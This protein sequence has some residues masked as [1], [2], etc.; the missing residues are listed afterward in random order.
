MG[1]GSS[2]YDDKDDQE[3]LALH[4]LSLYNDE[5][6]C[7]I[8][9]KI[10]GGETLTSFEEELLKLKKDIV[11][12]TKQPF[13]SYNGSLESLATV[14]SSRFDRLVKV[15]DFDSFSC[16]QEKVTAFEFMRGRRYLLLDRILQA[17]TNM[18]SHQKSI[19][20]GGDSD[21][22]KKRSV[23]WNLPATQSGIE[24]RNDAKVGSMLSL[25]MTLSLAKTFGSQNSAMLIAILQNLLQSWS[26]FESLCFANSSALTLN[27]VKQFE[28]FAMDIIGT[29]YKDGTG[30]ELKSLAVSFLFAIGVLRGSVELISEASL[31]L[32]NLNL[33]LD[34]RVYCL[35]KQ[36]ENIE[37][38]YAMHF[39]QKCGVAEKIPVGSLDSW[40]EEKESN[41][42]KCVISRTICANGSHVYM[43][44]ENSSSLH[45][46]STGGRGNVPGDV[47][48]TCKDVVKTIKDELDKSGELKSSERKEKKTK[49]EKKLMTDC[50]I[51]TI[52][53]GSEFSVSENKLRVTHNDSNVEHWNTVIGSKQIPNLVTSDYAERLQGLTYFEVKIVSCSTD[54]T[55]GVIGV[56]FC[57]QE[58]TPVSHADVIGSASSFF[59]LNYSFGGLL[60][61]NGV[62]MTDELPSFTTG[63]IIGC[64]MDVTSHSIF[65][66]KNGN[67]IGTAFSLQDESV[68]A[69]MLTPAVSFQGGHVSEVEVNFGQSAFSYSGEG[70]KG[71]FCASAEDEREDDDESVDK[72]EEMR[73]SLAYVNGKIYFHYKKYLRSNQF[74]VFDSN[75][76]TF[77]GIET[78]S[79]TQSDELQIEQFSINLAT[80]RLVDIQAQ[81]GLELEL[82]SARLGDQDITSLLRESVLFNKSWLLASSQRILDAVKATNSMDTVLNLSVGWKEIP[83]KVKMMLPITSYQDYIIGV[84]HIGGENKLYSAYRRL[85]FVNSKFSSGSADDDLIAVVSTCWENYLEAVA[86]AKET[87]LP[88]V[89]KTDWEFLKKYAKDV[90]ENEVGL[91]LEFTTTTDDEDPYE[92][93]YTEE[94]GVTWNDIVECLSQEAKDHGDKYR[95]VFLDTKDK[96]VKH[97]FDLEL[98][99]APEFSKSNF[100]CMELYFNGVQLQTNL[101][102]VDEETS[103]ISSWKFSFK[104]NGKYQA[105]EAAE[106]DSS[107]V[108]YNFS[109]NCFDM[110][111]NTFFALTPDG[112][113]VLRWK[114]FG[115]SPA[116]VSGE[117]LIKEVGGFDEA[118]FQ[119][120]TPT[121]QSHSIMQILDRISGP[122]QVSDSSLNAQNSRMLKAEIRYSDKKPEVLV[123]VAGKPVCFPEKSKETT[124]VFVVVFDA[125]FETEKIKFFSLEDEGAL[126]ATRFVE[127]IEN[128]PL[129]QCV[130]VVITDMHDE[131]L[132]NGAFEIL[133][134]IGVSDLTHSSSKYLIAIGRKGLA[135]GL[136]DFVAEDG[137]PNCTLSRLLPPLQVP[138]C[139]EPT[140]RTMTNLLTIC[141]ACSK[142]YETNKSTDIVQ[143]LTVVLNLLALNLKNITSGLPVKAYWKL[144]GEDVIKRLEKSLKSLMTSDLK[145]RPSLQSTIT[146]M[147]YASMD[148]LYSSSNQKIEAL[149]SYSEG[150]KVSSTSA[151]AS[152]TKSAGDSDIL[153][154]LLTDVSLPK[155]YLSSKSRSGVDRNH[156]TAILTACEGLFRRELRNAVD[157]Y[158]SDG[159]YLQESLSKLYGTVV[160]VLSNI[161]TNLLA[162]DLRTVEIS[163]GKLTL[164]S[165]SSMALFLEV[166]TIMARLSADL[167]TI[168]SSAFENRVSLT[169]DD[170]LLELLRK[171]FFSFLESSPLASILP[172]II[173]AFTRLVKAGGYQFTNKIID[174]ALGLMKELDRCV[175]S[176]GKVFALVPSEQ[177]KISDSVPQ[178]PIKKKVIESEHP[179][180]SNMNEKSVFSFPGATKVQIVFDQAT[181]TETNCDYL[182]FQDKEG[183][184]LHPECSERF[185]G[186]DGGQNWPGTDGRPPLEMNVSEFTVFFHSDGSVE[187]WGYK[188]TVT[189]FF[190]PKTGA[191]NRLE[192]IS[193]MNLDLVEIQ[194]ALAVTLVQGPSWKPI[195]DEYSSWMENS[196]VRP[197]YF[198]FNPDLEDDVDRF[199]HD[200][201]ELP[202]DTPAAHFLQV[203]RRCV[204][205]DQGSVEAINRS[206]Y[207]TCAA[208]IRANNLSSE[209]YAIAT[210]KRAQPSDALVKAWTTGQKMREYF[211]LSDVKSSM[212]GN[213]NNGAQRKPKFSLYEGAPEEVVEEASKEIVARAQ[214][215]LRIPKEKDMSNV[216]SLPKEEDVDPEQIDLELDS[217]EA[218]SPIRPGST[219]TSG[220]SKW[221]MAARG[222]QMMRQVSEETRKANEIWHSLVGEAV[223]KEKLKNI[224]EH[225]RKFAEKNKAANAMTTT[226]KVLHFVQSDVDIARLH[227][228]N[229]LRNKRAISRTKGFDMFFKLLSGLASFPSVVSVV[230]ERFTQTMHKLKRE[231]GTAGTMVHYST[232]LEG[233]S[234]EQNNLLWQKFSSIYKKCVEII[235]STSL[236]EKNPDAERTILN[237]LHACALDFDSAD[238]TLVYESGL[239][240]CLEELLSLKASSTPDITQ[241]AT[242]LFELLVGR[243]VIYE[244]NVDSSSTEP[245]PLS[246]KLISALE[247]LLRVGPAIS[248]NPC[249]ASSELSVLKDKILETGATVPYSAQY[250]SVST[251][252]SS[253]PLAHT[254]VFWVKRKSSAILDAPFSYANLVGRVVCLGVDDKEQMALGQ[255]I[256]ANADTRKVKIKSQDRKEVEFTLP[257]GNSLENAPFNLMDPTV[258]GYLFSKGASGVI[259][260]ADRRSRVPSITSIEGIL[261]NDGRIQIS[262]SFD[263]KDQIRLYSKAIPA[264]VWVQVAVTFDHN[265]AVSLFINAE[266]HASR[267]AG[268]R[269]SKV[270]ELESAHPIA[271]LAN[272]NEALAVDGSSTLLWFDASTKFSS[273]TGE[274][275]LSQ[276]DWTQSFSVTDQDDFPGFNG[277]EAVLR[278]GK[279]NF[280]YNGSEVQSNDWGYKL[281][282]RGVSS[283]ELEEARNAGTRLSWYVGQPPTYVEASGAASLKGASAIVHHLQVFGA[284]L[285]KEQLKLL[286]T[287]DTTIAT[288]DNISEPLLLRRLSVL[289]RA[290]SNL[291]NL[292]DLTM[293]RHFGTSGLISTLFDL[294]SHRSAI[295]KCSALQLARSILPQLEREYVDG[296]AQR[297]GMMAG[298]AS[299]FVESVVFQVGESLNTWI[300][301]MLAMDDV[302]ESCPRDGY[303]YLHSLTAIR[304]NLI[305][306][307]VEHKGVW[308]ELSKKSL[309]SLSVAA[310]D[311]I[312]RLKDKLKLERDQQATFSVKQL[313][314][315]RESDLQAATSVFSLLSLLGGV[316]NSIG[317]GATVLYVDSDS[318]I[319]EEAIYLGPIEKEKEKDLFSTKVLSDDDDKEFAA[320][321]L[322]RK[323]LKYTTVPKS[324]ITSPNDISVDKDKFKSFLEDCF[325]HEHLIELFGEILDIS[326]VDTRAKPS[327]K[328]EKV[329]VERVFESA[330]PYSDNFEFSEEI[331]IDGAESLEIFFDPQSSTEKDCDF[332]NFWKSSDRSVRL[333]SPF[334][335]RNGTQNWPGCEGRPSLVVPGS[336]VFYSFQTDASNNDWGYKFTVR[337]Q[338]KRQSS[339]G[340]LKPLPVFSTLAQI[341]MMGMKS[342]T[343]VAACSNDVVRSLGG[344]LS[345]VIKAAIQPTPANT[346]MMNEK[347][348]MKALV[349]ESSHP[350][351]DNMDVV[352]PVKVP[353]AKRFIISFD[354]ETRTENNCDYLEFYTDRNRGT[355]CPN[356][357]KYTGG[358]DGGTSNWP[359]MKDRPPLIIEGDSFAFFFHS[360][361]SVNDWGYKMYVQP[362][363]AKVKA[364]KVQAIRGAGFSAVAAESSF[365][366]LQGV[367]LDG[368]ALPA[369]R[370]YFQ[371]AV[372]GVAD[373]PEY[374]ERSILGL[375]QKRDEILSQAGQFVVPTASVNKTLTVKLSY[376][377]A[378]DEVAVYE[379]HDL[380]SSVRSTIRR[381]QVL[382]VVEEWNDWLK[383][384]E[385]RDQRNGPVPEPEIGWIQRRTQ[386]QFSL[387]LT[388]TPFVQPMAI[389]TSADDADKKKITSKDHPMYAVQDGTDEQ[390]FFKKLISGKVDDRQLLQ[391]DFP[392]I[393]EAMND[394]AAIASGEHSKRLAELLMTRNDDGYN[395]EDLDLN[396]LMSYLNISLSEA[397]DEKCVD[398]ERAN[399][400]ADAVFGLILNVSDKFGLEESHSA[401]VK[402]VDTSLDLIKAC[403]T[404]ST[405]SVSA[406]TQRGYMMTVESDHQYENNM[407]KDWTVSFPGAKRLELVF[408]E[409]CSTETNCDY[410]NI[411]DVQRQNK[412]Y[413]PKIHGYR[414]VSNKHWPGVGGVP[415]LVLEHDSCIINFVTD[416]STVDWGF[417]VVVYGIYDEASNEEVSKYE[418][419]QKKMNETSQRMLTMAMWATHRLAKSSASLHSS[420]L[421]R[422]YSEENFRIMKNFSLLPVVANHRDEMVDIL[423]SFVTNMG[424]MIMTNASLRQEFVELESSIVNT[425]RLAYF[426]ETENGTKLTQVST[427]LQAMVQLVLALHQTMSNYMIDTSII[428]SRSFALS[429]ATVATEDKFSFGWKT[430][431]YDHRSVCNAKTLQWEI[432]IVKMGSTMP[433]VGLICNTSTKMT[434]SIGKNAGFCEIGY[435]GNSVN[436]NGTDVVSYPVPIKNW[437]VGDVIKITYNQEAGTVQFS[438]NDAH[439]P[440]AIGPAAAS[441]LV[442]MNASNIDFILAISTLNADDVYDARVKSVSSSALG[443]TS[444]PN[445]SDWLCSILDVEHLF[446][447]LEGKILHAHPIDNG[448]APYCSRLTKEYVSL[449]ESAE[450]SPPEVVKDIEVPGASTLICGLT[451]LHTGMN[452]E[453]LFHDRDGHFLARL[454]GDKVYTTEF[455]GTAPNTAL[456]EFA[457]VHPRNLVGCNDYANELSSAEFKVHPYEDGGKQHAVVTLVDVPITSVSYSSEFPPT[458]MVWTDSALPLVEHLHFNWRW[459][460]MSDGTKLR[461]LTVESGTAQVNALGDAAK[462][463]F[464][465]TLKPIHLKGLQ[466][467]EQD[468]KVFS[469]VPMVCGSE[470]FNVVVL[471]HAVSASSTLIIRES[472]LE[473]QASTLWL[474]LNAIG[475]MK[476][477]VGNNPSSGGKSLAIGSRVV[478]GPAWCYGKEDGGCGQIGVVTRLREWK[479]ASVGGVMVRWESGFEG[480][481][482]Y[483]F[484]QQFDVIAVDDNKDSQEN[485]DATVLAKVNVHNKQCL[486]IPGNFVRVT[487]RLSTTNSL[488]KSLSSESAAADVP[489]D[490]SSAANPDH[491][492]HVTCAVYPL[493]PR[494]VCLED[495]RFEEFRKQLEAAFM[496]K[497]YATLNALAKHIDKSMQS[498]SIAKDR[499]FR[500][501]WS[502]F[503]PT[504][505][506]LVRSALLKELVEHPAIEI[507]DNSRPIASSGPACASKNSKQSRENSSGVSG[508]DTNEEGIGGLNLSAGL[509]SEEQ[510]TEVLS[511]LAA[512]EQDTN[513]RRRRSRSGS[514]DS[515]DDD[516]VDDDDD[517][518][519]GEDDE[520]DEDDEDNIGEED[521]RLQEG[522]FGED[523]PSAQESHHSRSSSSSSSS[524][525]S[526]ASR[527]SSRAASRSE[528]V[529]TSPVYSP[530]ASPAA[531]P[532]FDLFTAEDSVPQEEVVLTCGKCNN[533]IGQ[534]QFD[535]YWSCDGPEHSGYNHFGPGT[536]YGCQTFRRCNWWMCGDCFTKGQEKA[537]NLQNSDAVASAKKLLAQAPRHSVQM[538]VQAETLFQM[539]QA[540]NFHLMRAI[541]MIDLHRSKP[542]PGTLTHTLTR[543]RAL[544]LSTIKQEL[545]CN[546]LDNTRGSGGQFELFLSRS[547]ARKYAALGKTDVDGNWSVFAQAFRVMHPMNPENLRRND[548]LYVTKLM[549][550]HAQ[551]AGGPYRE[552]FDTYCQELQSST[553][554]LFVRT[555]NGRGA[556]GMNREKWVLNPSACSR[557][558]MEML[559]FVGKLMGIAI[560]SKEYLALNI[561]SIIWKLIAGDTPTIEDLEAVD[562]S[563]V[564]SLKKVVDAEGTDAENFSY[565]YCL[566]FATMSSDLR[567]VELI[568]GGSEKEVKF[569]NRAEFRDRVIQYR[570]HEFDRQAAA[571]RSGLATIVPID[572]LSLFT[573]DQLEEMVCGKAEIDV[574]LLKSVTE[575]SSCAPSDAHVEFFWQVM[576]EFT[577]EERSALIRFAWGRSRLPLTA[578]GFSQ[579]FKI[580]NLE[581]HPA[582][583]HLPEA[584]TCFFS[585]DLPRYSTLEITREKL[586]YVIFN[587]TAIDGDDTS[588]G[589]QVAAM[590]WEE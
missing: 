191:R 118:S 398:K 12:L 89:F 108:S 15:D 304:L 197:E 439:M 10:S 450:V 387:A 413:E 374:H 404:V 63:D 302:H 271:A 352:T 419:E 209:A 575:Y 557:T 377:V 117:D 528:Y 1:S 229:H 471:E 478:R 116:I 503:T 289:R 189:A 8:E 556:V 217:I 88:D 92:C 177:A 457:P 435:S 132:R 438:I 548:R 392:A 308:Q 518:D 284:R 449:H 176:M 293:K 200:L 472:N 133:K 146:S 423:S 306:S 393:E 574:E 129:G 178:K 215:L 446:R 159:L 249:E 171:D 119:A 69:N 328:E 370:H 474:K 232:A 467:Q 2:K 285:S 60:Q 300:Q 376:S 298:N 590:G 230:L 357:D 521:N 58:R 445:N 466:G 426:N 562:V 563:I 543:H 375:F 353:G 468:M 417:K 3:F 386:N 341:K 517:D 433:V 111:T 91:D 490:A 86:E 409:E 266:H 279:V 415:K 313:C 123:T 122:F 250:A 571:V 11:D 299:N 283:K 367:V 382:G 42:D 582:D 261:V 84:Q 67:H 356:S 587:C 321:L 170:K 491:L 549:G 81:E 102:I 320:I 31:Y 138:L 136:G 477:I 381:G 51:N 126:S 331:T 501:H 458:S 166:F 253:L 139:M 481:Y 145:S 344:N 318:G 38:K 440:L 504:P 553:L 332:I 278:H 363:A 100:D 451:D 227:E 34:S 78:F 362:I 489:E 172:T 99:E 473:K 355:R 427:A 584:H 272:V 267:V 239:V 554:S 259:S 255:I 516:E 188:F 222:V 294:M 193:K 160:S 148:L 506:D 87:V 179:Y 75:M 514:G 206:V 286:F 240:E 233:C 245:T 20:D 128:L 141:E 359:G 242:S 62:V 274:V 50:V 110:S 310:I 488:V 576:D 316:P 453:V 228:V 40:N 351:A 137:S 174:E 196:L 345:K 525:S 529:P 61:G 295:V 13:D 164:N 93:S 64:G 371:G 414:S 223:S 207:A 459:F 442:E 270:K 214:F 493:F 288:I 74:A 330:H 366:M 109:A 56:G 340:I 210:G 512:A 234:P 541:P 390:Q 23:Y 335:G 97:S 540:L 167:L 262:Y 566:T 161:S 570:L 21:S 360:D 190:P 218:L 530:V 397:K 329:V 497:N 143:Y 52:N 221:R 431:H 17:Q 220:S 462:P 555:A 507:R 444:T 280:A 436:V 520:D 158:L 527:R 388:T 106:F 225:R 538:I 199:L 378:V 260:E 425:M 561:P 114:N 500:M 339:I 198:S 309:R 77:L 131:D 315:E 465:T 323:G 182:I 384:K 235:R 26:S 247:R 406:P 534:C 35:V 505:E 312:R 580:Q 588:T 408:S 383:L 237:A 573:W 526:A 544:I 95:V 236:E 96:K 101:N 33:K 531:S 410:L 5:Y 579:R 269:S 545:F 76:L 342:L 475:F 134:S 268:T 80:E 187:D 589:M 422:F 90:E 211:K 498:K 400:M 350:Y 326:T 564:N 496:P 513:R 70:V 204:P 22:G 546:A 560:R 53:T 98:S 535:G 581:K 140:A 578:A 163:Q 536:I 37:P 461:F 243:L 482:R 502:E 273:G 412:L 162:L 194:S 14:F 551:D 401:A 559:A 173:N 322:K 30:T 343:Q 389:A 282:Y 36:L 113:F 338:V 120:L 515:N 317:V 552:S 523:E 348:E 319:S 9:E 265:N 305:H 537:K 68:E 291:E 292:A 434:N 429:S 181:R 149:R 454:K 325:D 416:G 6:I 121:G 508:E 495:A 57:D 441:P 567:E 275:Q 494:K 248:P 147:F 244:P 104:K 49:K 358:K 44:H 487:I 183:N 107:K 226:E 124:G 456:E 94:Q 432:K 231:E 41:E 483:G 203:M 73:S 219:P 28:D 542:L 470:T 105:F 569:E 402:L 411:Y 16:M 333:G 519:D 464:P 391:Q 165:P 336:S 448:L 281:Y 46:I 499:F 72:S 55:R 303:Q 492:R 547:K 157:R 112:K 47:I 142:E 79:L 263:E 184:C 175:G 372:A 103:K 460:T 65:Y 246:K 452:D 71:P 346:V 276:G 168:I 583:G 297:Q 238:H 405:S 224:F 327:S 365:M 18:L 150:D 447:A 334:S 484:E 264:D 324:S 301:R 558:E 25:T 385:F 509:I 257:E 533:P 19:N 83:T 154:V 205:V 135:P 403:S 479:A 550:E 485:G 192:W 45:K 568:P 421:Q 565:V 180:R 32:M 43:F 127:F 455:D 511:A 82:A 155:N 195:E 524:S 213:M 307:F 144:L 394:Y 85:K 368:L 430:Y 443:K 486:E 59:L 24:P 201:A 27:T 258:G 396:D 212:E 361:G 476:A 428:D 522:F 186:R 296:N 251:N 169:K 364:K 256:D 347:V 373:A 39:P 7:A 115:A 29:E 66:T 152:E 130:V 418:E 480:Y 354:P 241:S 156:T 254:I 252:T 314:K 577:N 437:A 407:N 539:V 151:S 54:S 585:I 532:T 380:N 311:A 369:D 185:T 399:R 208:I 586:R 48:C 349:F 290:V 216:I 287:K 420:I 510:A 395:T 463:N 572:L 424:P 337:S 202:V 4:G 379:T 153:T 277:N 125:T 469:V